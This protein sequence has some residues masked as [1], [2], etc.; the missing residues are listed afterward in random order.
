MLADP[1]SVTINAIAHSLPLTNALP[2]A[3]TYTSA[4]GNV[5]LVTKQNTTAKRFRREVRLINRKVATDPLSAASSNQ[6]VSVYL[7]IDEPRFGFTDTELDQ[8]VQSLKG[9]LTSGNV[10]K[11]AGGEM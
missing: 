3:R 7:V 11:I 1:Q 2:Q 6:S 8:L 10:A 4:D 9:F 5:S